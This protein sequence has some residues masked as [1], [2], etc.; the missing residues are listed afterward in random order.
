MV[1]DSTFMLDQLGHTR[2]GPQPS[3]IT[4]CFGTP[5][6]A[7]FDFLQISRRQTGSPTTAAGGFQGLRP[8]CLQGRRSPANGLAM[9]TYLPSNICLVPTLLEQLCRLQ[10]SALQGLKIALDSSW[11][12]HEETLHENCHFVT[13]LREPQ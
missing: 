6:Q 10:T 13:I 1:M 8:Q 5:L 12:S 7:E 3:L 2:Q 9:H 4:Q 11:V